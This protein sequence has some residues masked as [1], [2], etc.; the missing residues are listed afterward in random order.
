VRVLVTGAAGFVGTAVVRC[1]QSSGHQVAAFLIP[2][3]LREYLIY[4]PAT[5]SMP[6]R[7]GRLSLMSTRSVTLPP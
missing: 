1:L 5:S 2:P 4:V 7:W 6:H 3:S